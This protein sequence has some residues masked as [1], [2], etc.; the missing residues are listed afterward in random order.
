MREPMIVNH[1][2][3]LLAVAFIGAATPAC[4]DVITDWND[5]AVVFGVTRTM[6]PAAAERV[7]A[8]VHVAMFDAVNSIDHKYRS[9]LVQLPAIAATS[10][11]A[12]AAAAAGTVLAGINAPG[13]PDVKPSLASYLA[14]IPDGPAKTE[15][16]KLGEAVAARIL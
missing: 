9:Y 7:I 8:M 12:A 11:E 5:Q 14:A 10:R 13:Q 15:G 16:V 4:A 2:K 3:F 6:A 1:Y